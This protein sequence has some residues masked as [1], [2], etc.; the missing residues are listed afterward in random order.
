MYPQLSNSIKDTSYASHHNGQLR[1]YP[2]SRITYC[3]EWSKILGGGGAHYKQIH[4]TTQMRG[5]YIFSIIFVQGGKRVSYPLIMA[6]DS[7][8]EK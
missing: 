3:Y 4:Y 8:L 7:S 2:Q 6:K 1:F 5:S